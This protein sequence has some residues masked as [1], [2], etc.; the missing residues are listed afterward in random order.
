MKN[1]VD[2]EINEDFVVNDFHVNKKYDLGKFGKVGSLV[3]NEEYGILWGKDIECINIKL[4]IQ[5]CKM[6][7]HF[8]STSRIKLDIDGVI[9]LGIIPKKDHKFLYSK[10]V[11]GIFGPGTIISNA[12]INIIRKIGLK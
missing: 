5:L 11:I 8:Y 3:L 7:I 6:G 2:M 9:N 1:R 4:V 10:G 12:A